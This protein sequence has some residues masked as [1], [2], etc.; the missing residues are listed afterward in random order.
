MKI[1]R[2]QLNKFIYE[3]A[4]QNSFDSFNSLREYVIDLISSGVGFYKNSQY[5]KKPDLN[6]LANIKSMLIQEAW[7]DQIFKQLLSKNIVYHKESDKFQVDAFG[8]TYLISRLSLG[9]D[10]TAKQL[11][12]IIQHWLAINNEH[13]GGAHR[14]QSV[15][16]RLNIEFARRTGKSENSKTYR[17]ILD[18]YHQIIKIKKPLRKTRIAY[19]LIS[20]NSYYYLG[21][22]ALKKAQN[23]MK[24]AALTAWR[25]KVPGKLINVYRE[26]YKNYFFPEIFNDTTKILDSSHAG[27]NDIKNL[28]MLITRWITKF[29]EIEADSVKIDTFADRHLPT[30]KKALGLNE[31][32]MKITR[33]ELRRLLIESMEENEDAMIIAKLNARIKEL[34]T[35]RDLNSNSPGEWEN[36]NSMWNQLYDMVDSIYGSDIP[37]DLRVW[38]AIGPLTGDVWGVG[39]TQEEA[40]TFHLKNPGFVPT[41]ADGRRIKQSEIIDRG[42]PEWTNTGYSYMRAQDL[43]GLENLFKENRFQNDAVNEGT[44]KSTIADLIESEDIENLKMG[45]ELLS[46]MIEAELFPARNQYDRKRIWQLTVP[47]LRIYNKNKAEIIWLERKIAGIGTNIQDGERNRQQMHNYYD[48]NPSEVQGGHSSLYPGNYPLDY[49]YDSGI[50]RLKA[51]QKNIDEKIRTIKDRND[52]I[53]E[54]LEMSKQWHGFM[55][56]DKA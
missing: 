23:I 9:D 42:M 26:N 28:I 39:L 13:Y 25:S 4:R 31:N 40:A 47:I 21:Q 17:R 10:E 50:Q 6:D 19:N 2:R 52:I 37:P 8:K 36:I 22:E 30:F 45:I 51:Q 32:K 44:I 33:S 38:E 24:V 56:T 3:S 43:E 49:H 18:G 48:E 41:D 5:G 20:N 12:A 29:K 11:I 53:R 55:N 15:Q 16:D 27:S 7:P 1:T 46:S 14:D 54:Y 34:E 35:H